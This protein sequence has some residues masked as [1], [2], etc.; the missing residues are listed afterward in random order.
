[1]FIECESRFDIREILIERGVVSAVLLIDLDASERCRL[2]QIESIR[3]KMHRVTAHQI[4]KTESDVDNLINAYTALLKK[5]EALTLQLQKHGAGTVDSSKNESSVCSNQI[6][7]DKSHAQSSSTET[8]SMS[9]LKA[10]FNL[11]N[12]PKG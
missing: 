8:D 4:T 7:Q 3:L 10:S 9:S 12:K 2:E 6:E 5:Y 11:T 1:M